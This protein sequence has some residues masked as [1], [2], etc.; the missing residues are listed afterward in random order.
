MHSYI[1]HGNTF[2]FHCSVTISEQ[3]FA[4]RSLQF[5]FVSEGGLFDRLSTPAPIIQNQNDI[6]IHIWDDDV[7][8]NVQSLEWEWQSFWHM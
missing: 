8:A 7:C 4:P 6:K 5:L 3:L 2:H 1:A